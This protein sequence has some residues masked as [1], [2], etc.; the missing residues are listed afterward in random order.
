[1]KMRDIHEKPFSIHGLADTER[2]WR[3][4]ADL[5]DK[6][7]P[8]VTNLAK[9]SSGARVR[10]ATDSERISLY[11]ELNSECSMPHMPRS[12]SSGVDIFVNGEFVI[13]MR[14]NTEGRQAF[15]DE[16]VLPGGKTRKEV[17][18][19]LPLYNGVSRM[20]IG[21]DDDAQ[22]WPAKPYKYPKPVVFYGSSITQ[23]GCACRPANPHPARTCRWADSELYCLGF[24]G[25]ARAEDSIID[26]I[27]GLDM[28]VFVLDYDHNAPSDEHL[29]NTHKKFYDR[30]RAAQ[31]NLP[32][33]MLSKPDYDSALPQ[34]QAE[35]ERRRQ[36]I[37]ATYDAAIAAGDKNAYYIDGKTLFEDDERDSCTVDRCHPNDLGFYRMSKAI[38]PVLMRCLGE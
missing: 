15:A 29:L 14:P 9:H 20:S 32:I 31:P 21:L 23:G 16:N 24:S 19:Y 6:V 27:C 28:S 2:M 34:V 38:Y 13:N 10:F 4:P 35:N 36:I 25:A 5:I 8:S 33:I 1:M 22:L 7:N 3:L 11:V 26:Y 30:L 18:I 17:T 12:G 37:R